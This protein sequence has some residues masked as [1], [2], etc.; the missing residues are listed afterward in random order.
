MGGA[1]IAAALLETAGTTT[2]TPQPAP[3]LTS[4]ATPSPSAPS[5]K[6]TQSQAPR[7]ARQC[8]GGGKLGIYSY[9]DTCDATDAPIGPTPD[10]SQQQFEFYNYSSHPPGGDTTAPPVNGLETGNLY[11]TA[12]AG[13]GTGEIGV[14]TADFN[15]PSPTVGINIQNELYVNNAPAGS[16]V[17]LAIQAAFDNYIAYLQ[18]TN[19]LT[20]KYGHLV[21][22]PPCPTGASACGNCV[23]SPT[24]PPTYE[25]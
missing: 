1:A 17:T 6:P 22:P 21:A 8:T 9:W 20:D 14:Y 13:A 12:T 10:A 19:Q 5:T 7:T 25:Y 3:T 23:S 18:C 24:C 4:P 2:P 16:Q 15:N 11:L